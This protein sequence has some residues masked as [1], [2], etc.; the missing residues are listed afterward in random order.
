[1]IVELQDRR[2]IAALQCVDAVVGEPILAS[3][4]FQGSGVRVIRNRLGFYLLTAAL[5]FEDYIR[6][7]DLAGLASPLATDVDLQINDPG[8]QYLP[9]RFRLTVPR[10]LSAEAET[11]AF[12]PAV[13]SLFPSPAFARPQPGWAVFRASIADAEGNPLPWALIRVSRQADPVIDAIAQADDRGEAL[14]AVAGIPMTLV[15]GDSDPEDAEALPNL[16]PDV[17]TATATVIFDPA[18]IAAIP[19][20]D[21]LLAR[22]E[23]LPSGSL[24]LSIAAGR[25]QSTTLAFNL[26]PPS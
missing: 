13:I 10:S 16:L 6:Q 4:Q 5:G 22:R 7:F 23:T 18:P 19:D 3:L 12:R 24:P 21:D 9:R 17:V 14:I 2:L 15:S 25:S 20:P 8:G 26:S 1:M 11:S